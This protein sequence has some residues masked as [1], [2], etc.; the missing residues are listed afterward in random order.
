[1]ELLSK[2]VFS[3]ALL[4]FTSFILYLFNRFYVTPQRL[5]SKLRSQGLRGPSP[6]FLLGNIPDFVKFQPKDIKAL[7]EDGKATH[8]WARFTFPLFEHW[9][10][11][12]GRRY[13]F[14]LGTYQVVYI[15]DPQ[16]AKEISLSTSLKLGKPFFLQKNSETLLGKGILTSDGEFWAHQR[17][18]IA[19]E[20]YA[21]KV[22]NLV[23]I[24]LNS[25]KKLIDTWETEIEKQSGT[26]NIKVDGDLQSFASIVISETLFGHSNSKVINELQERFKR[27]E[28]AMKTPILVGGIPGLWYVPTKS[29]IEKWILKKE[30]HSRIMHIVNEH[31]SKVEVL[32][33]IINGA[34]MSAPG[35]AAVE[36][37]I[38]DNCKNV[39]L[40]G[41]ESTANT[42][43]WTLM[44]LATHPEWQDRARAEVAEVCGESLPDAAM[45][46]KMKVLTTVIQEA[47]RLY[48]P[49]PFIARETLEDMKFGDL[50]I[51]K[52]VGV[53]VAVMP[54]HHDPELWGPDPSKFNPERFANGIG[55]ACKMPQA[56]IP[57]GN[58]PHICA[59]QLFAMLEIKVVLA[60]I[61]SKFSFSLDP[62]Y[63]HSPVMENIIRPG[64]GVNL[65]MHRLTK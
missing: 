43:A 19:P 27:L 5:R 26:A 39:Y 15:T 6:S 16:L 4:C 18:T 34:K 10:S 48:P 32:Q 11:Q 50:E 22:K 13:H 23:H 9:S 49:G 12:Y 29:N 41:L 1:M 31:S 2:S 37:L 54:L 21:D 38:V 45:L 51:P 52:G 17:K 3:V 20:F 24:M 61:L 65:I 44:L 36:Q 56:Y 7:T 14:A 59:G 30:I 8:D 47:L 63:I 58:G 35:P 53:W 60:I 46:S 62:N 33:S 55:S 25:A 40:A 64:H 42:A 28:R 57:F